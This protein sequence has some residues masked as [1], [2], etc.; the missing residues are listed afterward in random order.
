MAFE[1]PLE[2]VLNF[3]RSVEHQQQLRLRAAQ[4]RLEQV[5]HW[6][7]RM[8][9][10]QDAL[11]AAQSHQLGAGTT[12]A[13]L[14]FSVQCESQL[15]GQRRELERQLAALQQLHEQLRQAFQKARRERETLEDLR[16]QQL[17]IYKKETARR[18]QRRVDDLFLMRRVHPQRG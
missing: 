6:I 13:E 11:R 4:E 3:R 2:S 17:L 1:F 15:L 7:A 16:Q 12:F 14:H 18:E 8:D 9:S 5:R 10:H